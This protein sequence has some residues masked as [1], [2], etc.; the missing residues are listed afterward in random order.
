MVRC[1]VIFGV[2]DFDE[3]GL[4]TVDETVLAMR[5]T[6]GGLCKLASINYPLEQEIENI[7]TSV[8]R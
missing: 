5:A 8:G 1:A 4:L 6:I 7:A 2:Y 3:S